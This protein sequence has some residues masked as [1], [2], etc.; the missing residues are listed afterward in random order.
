MDFVDWFDFDPLSGR[1]TI[2]DNMNWDEIPVENIEPIPHD[3]I[4]VD[5]FTFSHGVEETKEN[6][7]YEEATADMSVFQQVEDIFHR[8][9][10]ANNPSNATSIPTESSSNEIQFGRHHP[11]ERI[12][13]SPNAT[14]VPMERDFAYQ[15]RPSNEDL[16]MKNQIL[17]LQLQTLQQKSRTQ[18]AL[19]FY[20]EFSGKTSELQAFLQ[21][22][23]FKIKNHYDSA[24]FFRFIRN[25]TIVDF[26]ET[27]IDVSLNDMRQ[28]LDQSSISIDEDELLFESI[29]NSLSTTYRVKLTSQLTLA[30]RRGSNSGALAAVLIAKECL[31]NRKPIHVL[32]HDFYTL[33]LEKSS[34]DVCKFSGIV[35]RRFQELIA[36]K[37][38]ITANGR[39][40]D[41]V[42]EQLM[43]HPNPMFTTMVASE[44]A[45]YS[46]SSVTIRHRFNI[47]SLLTLATKFYTSL[48]ISNSPTIEKYEQLSALQ[49]TGKV[50]NVTNSTKTSEHIKNKPSSTTTYRSWR[51]PTG[52]EPTTR[53]AKGKRFYFCSHHKWNRSHHDEKCYILHPESR[54]DKKLQKSSSSNKSIPDAN[55]AG[56]PTTPNVDPVT[57]WELIQTLKH[58]I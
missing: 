5:Q 53:N 31:L 19:A 36:Y 37:Y 13:P 40:A 33:S 49:S 18:K 23:Q 21:N 38:N 45:K 34:Y 35:V 12:V 10:I 51:E 7:F 29:V 15:P 27:P 46:C 41:M 4:N 52:D 32:A 58:T 2:V 14:T 3:D 25:G 6:D 57:A 54:P 17:L 48:P 8:E 50:Q 43:S 28:H 39:H 20:N 9:S 16:I 30:R 47:K 55:L 56:A 1:Q 42:F 11:R 26:I 44:Y 22:L 24:K